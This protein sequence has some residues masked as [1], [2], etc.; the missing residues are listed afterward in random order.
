[1]SDPLKLT[2]TYCKP[3]PVRKCVRVTA[4]LLVVAINA[5]AASYPIRYCATC[6]HMAGYTSDYERITEY[7]FEGKETKHMWA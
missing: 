3:M 2:S 4:L 5:G 7:L 1:M 6:H